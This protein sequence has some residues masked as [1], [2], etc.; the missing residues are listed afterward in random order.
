MQSKLSPEELEQAPSHTN[1]IP[2][3]IVKNVN[4]PGKVR[5]DFGAGAKFQSTSLNKYLSKAP[6]LLNRLIR[7]LIRF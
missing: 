3:N 5:V 1:Y 7:V 2:H 4:K 6:G